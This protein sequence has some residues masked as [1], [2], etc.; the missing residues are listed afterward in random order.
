MIQK[1]LEFFRHD[2]VLG[3]NGDITDFNES[4]A[5]TNLF[6]LKVKLT[7]QTGNNGTKYVEI[8][9][10]LKYLSNFCRTLESSLINCEISLDLN[11][12]ENLPTTIS[13]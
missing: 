2:R 3:N 6:I 12:S 11:C 7:R 13:G 5:D 8:M 9:L 10:P 4:N 1:H